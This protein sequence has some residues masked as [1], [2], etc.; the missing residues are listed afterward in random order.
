MT[1]H[2]DGGLRCGSARVAAAVLAQSVARCWSSNTAQARSR[3]P[4]RTVMAPKKRASAPPTGPRNAKAQR[5]A[6]QQSPAPRS[7]HSPAVNV[8]G[9]DGSRAALLHRL[10]GVLGAEPE[11]IAGIRRREDK[12]SLI[13]VGVLVT[14]KSSRYAAE[15]QR[16][17][18]ERFP[19]VDEKIVHWKFPG[20][21]QRETPVG[22]IYV[23]VVMIMLLP[24]RKAALVRGECARLFVQYYGGD[25]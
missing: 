9:V 24:G 8:R 21:R 20:G 23:V 7:S 18:Q 6:S 14:G 12:F 5:R 2:V 3:I 15:Q 13:D 4:L 16:M 17:L 25:F 11:R 10:A 22:D 19:A 1:D